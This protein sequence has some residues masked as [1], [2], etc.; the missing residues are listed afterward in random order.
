MGLRGERLV[1]DLVRPREGQT[2]LSLALE[3]IDK[4]IE[5]TSVCLCFRDRAL[6]CMSLLA[7]CK[8]IK[9]LNCSAHDCKSTDFIVLIAEIRT[10]S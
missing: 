8:I 10:F 5:R 4:P 7:A 1:N 6:S 3:F 9:D 2:D